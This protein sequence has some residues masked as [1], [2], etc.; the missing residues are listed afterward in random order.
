MIP[1]EIYWALHNIKPLKLLFHLKLSTA[2]NICSFHIQFQFKHM[3]Y[4]MV[5]VSYVKS[6]L[7]YNK[8][9]HSVLLTKFISRKKLY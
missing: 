4:K 9:A 3:I 2:F 6:N 1:T 7:R 5:H 8:Q